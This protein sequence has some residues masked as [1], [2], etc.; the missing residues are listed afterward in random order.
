[1]EIDDGILLEDLDVI[2]PW[3]ISLRQAKGL[4]NPI[5][6]EHQGGRTDLIW[7]NA[8]VFGGISLDLT[9]IFGLTFFNKDKL[10]YY[11]TYLS[12]EEQVHELKT[13]F[14]TTLDKIGKFKQ[15]S[16]LTFDYSWKSKKCKIVLGTGDRFGT[17]YFLKLEY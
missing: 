15:H 8:K 6:R 9:A 11:F 16:D 14:E 5:V 4:G 1:M 10:R 2:L 7:K 17:F 3:F 13:Y 12:S